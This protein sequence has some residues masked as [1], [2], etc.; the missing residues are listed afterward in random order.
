MFWRCLERKLHLYLHIFKC[1]TKFTKQTHT[2][3]RKL[4]KYIFPTQSC[5]TVCDPMDY[6]VRGV[7][8]ARTLEWVATPFSRGSSQPRDRTQVSHIARRILYQLSHQGSPRILEWVAYPFSNRSSWPRNQTRVSC[9]AW[10]FFTN[11][12]TREAQEYN[13]IDNN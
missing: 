6:T 5:L 1:T 11:W 8:Q 7:L 12:A 13:I 9:I 3:Y 10:G 4:G 2:Y